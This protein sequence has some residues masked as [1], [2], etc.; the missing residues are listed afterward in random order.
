M[1]TELNCHGCRGRGWVL[2]S[3]YHAAVCPLCLG[4]GLE[5]DARETTARLFRQAFGEE[6]RRPVRGDDLISAV[7]PGEEADDAK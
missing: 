1:S 4:T 5:R 2:T 3:P 6:K 7:R